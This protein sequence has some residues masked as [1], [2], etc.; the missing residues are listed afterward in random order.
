M[1]WL[2]PI[3]IILKLDLIVVSTHGYSTW[4]LQ[5]WIQYD[6]YMLFYM[7][8]HVQSSFFDWRPLHGSCNSVVSTRILNSCP[9]LRLMLRTPTTLTLPTHFGF[10]VISTIVL[11]KIP[12]TYCYTKHV[13]TNHALHYSMQ[14][15]SVL[16]ISTRMGVRS[17][18]SLA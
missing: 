6:Q 13:L 5:T 4:Y 14:F 8:I 15:G 2:N 7:F 9:T 11:Y 18:C 17:A 1:H 12:W 16:S 10:Y 3:Y